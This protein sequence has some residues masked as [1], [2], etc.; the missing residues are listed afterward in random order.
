MASSR[1][2]SPATGMTDT[3]G[4]QRIA[5]GFVILSLFAVARGGEPCGMCR[6]CKQT[7]AGDETPY[8]DTGCG[9]RY[10]GAKHDE[11]WTPDPCD[12]CARWRG[13]NG[14]KQAPEKFPPWQLP[15][16]FFKK[17][18]RISCGEISGPY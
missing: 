17:W 4:M 12:A 10:C 11:C 13:C 9:P 16:Y 3:R 2:R 14:V 15:P 18:L 6:G 8:G 5:I 1:G 7:A